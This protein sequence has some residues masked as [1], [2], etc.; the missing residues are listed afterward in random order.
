MAGTLNKVMLIGNLG[1]D[2]EVRATEFA[3][4]VKFPIATSEQYTNREG[5]KVERTEWHNVVVLRKG[6]AEVCERYLRKGMKVYVEG[7]IQTRSWQDESGQTRYMTE[8]NCQEMTMLSSR[9]EG[10][11]T[12]N[13]SYSAPTQQ[14]PASD[15][16]GDDLP[17]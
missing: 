8:I 17:F 2:P 13:N 10:A 3:K 11:P 1:A 14:P 9:Q 12:S 16:D 5:Q 15:A 7:R 6:L 4:I